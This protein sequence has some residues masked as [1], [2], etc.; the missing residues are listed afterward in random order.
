MILGKIIIDQ[1]MSVSDDQRGRLWRTLVAGCA[2]GL[3]CLTAIELAVWLNGMP[4]T[5][6]VRT[7]HK[8]TFYGLF[9]AA[10]L[11]FSKSEG[12]KFRLAFVVLFYALPTLL[13]GNTSGI[14]IMILTVAPLM[15]LKPSD[16]KRA[17]VAFC[18]IYAIFAL[19]APFW[20]EQAYFYVDGSR[21]PTLPHV[22]SSMARLELWKDLVPQIKTAFWFGHG[23]D[24][25]RVLP[26]A[27]G[28]I[29]YYDLPD[30]PS[31]H[32][33]VFDIWYEL[34]LLG[35]IALLTIIMTA[36]ETV[37]NLRAGALLVA[38]IVLVGTVVELSVDHRIWL[39]WLQ[40]ALI[41]AISICVLT[42]TRTIADERAAKPRN[43]DI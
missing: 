19:T 30:I 6:A 4:A 20:V 41:L 21:I 43:H 11:L 17:L 7:F 28:E 40:G 25:T 23:A 13:L 34:G 15:L 1:L 36:A 14:G 29:K 10:F 31:A 38:F 37:M 35:I 3:V 22:S 2:I 12:A 27:F 8:T 5:T 26:L 9:F 33:M 16:L 32:N 18:L 39:S 24:T 42:G